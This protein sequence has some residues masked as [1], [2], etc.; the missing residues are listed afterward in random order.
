LHRP[1]NSKVLIGVRATLDIF[2]I[3]ASGDVAFE[4]QNVLFPPAITSPLTLVYHRYLVISL[5]Q[6]LPPHL[7]RLTGQLLT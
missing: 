3:G 4:P 2:C 5:L 6:P 7:A 1:N